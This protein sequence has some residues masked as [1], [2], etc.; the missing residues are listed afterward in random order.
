VAFL[1][2]AHQQRLRYYLPLVPS[3]SL[4][5]GWWLSGAIT[6]LR[7]VER[8]PWRW[9]AV[10]GGVLAVAAVAGGLTKRRWLTDAG[11]ALPG[12]VFET[13]AMVAAVGLITGA[14]ILGIARNQLRRPFAVAWTASALLLIV[15]YH[16]QL[17]RH[18]AAY[19]YPGVYAQAGPALRDAAVVAAWGVPEHPLAFYFNRPVVSVGEIGDLERLVTGGE[20][21]IGIVPDS[22][23]DQANEET[24]V[25]FTLVGRIRSHTIWL[26]QPG[27]SMVAENVAAVSS[28]R[29]PRSMRTVLSSFRGGLALESARVGQVAVRYAFFPL[30]WAP[31]LEWEAG[32]FALALLGLVFRL[33]TIGIGHETGRLDTTG[34]YSI[35]RHPIYCANLLIALGLSVFPHEWVGPVLVM[36]TGAIYYGRKIRDDEARLR[37]R[38][39]VEFEQWASAVPAILP[40]PSGYVPAGRRFDVR[41]ISQ[42]EWTLAAIV[43]IVPF[44]LDLVEDFLETNTLVFDPVWASMAVLGMMS[45]VA[46]RMLTGASPRPRTSG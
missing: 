16:W 27:P 13:L 9:Y 41:L 7:S 11:V 19:D 20:R 2:L 3:L 22:A 38:F 33:Y 46:S 21:V 4:L 26:V 36:V 34:P 24:G 37:S 23:R 10:M 18:N 14:L 1:A 30:T 32:A 15:G 43:L 25:S 40:R 5:T 42:R 44:L 39:S 8:V 31:D 12:S 45:L 17:Q 28:D 29:G 35:V 6:R